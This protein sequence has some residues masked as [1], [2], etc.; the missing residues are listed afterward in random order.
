M[1]KT[2][3]MKLFVTVI[4]VIASMTGC[5]KESTILSKKLMGRWELSSTSSFQGFKEFP[6]G[7]GFVYQ[8]NNDN[9]FSF[10]K[11]D[12]LISSGT[13]AL[14]NKKDC[15]P[16]VSDVLLN[17]QITVNGNASFYIK[18]SGDT[19]FF[20]TSSCFSDGVNSTYRRL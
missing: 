5:K 7:N 11:K 9:N 8:F 13:Y 17:L 2:S 4:I 18:I 12:S 19:L 1:Y 16:N 15:F 10:T 6:P 20:N 3:K 14:K